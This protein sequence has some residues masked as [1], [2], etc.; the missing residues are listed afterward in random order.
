M[1]GKGEAGVTAVAV[2]WLV[3]SGWRVIARAMPGGGHGIVLRPGAGHRRGG[4]PHL[5]RGG[6]I[7]DVIA[8]RGDEVLILESKPGLSK[9]DL[10]ELERARAGLYDRAIERAM[11]FRPSRVVLAIAARSERFHGPLA[12]RAR[13]VCDL[14]LLVSGKSCS[15]LWRAEEKH[16]ES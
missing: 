4:R 11:R 1:T 5:L 6:W 16:A 3:A 14:V 13:A 10:D 7:P 15:I 12:E 2:E 9:E 8:V